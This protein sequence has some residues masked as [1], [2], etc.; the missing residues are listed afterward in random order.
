M[1]TVAT[2]MAL[3]VPLKFHVIMIYIVYA[4]FVIKGKAMHIYIYH[5]GMAVKG[6][7]GD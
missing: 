6:A 7:I 4:T 2:H 1:Y 5:F 3:A